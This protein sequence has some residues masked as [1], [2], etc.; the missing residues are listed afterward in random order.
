MMKN[1]KN[2]IIDVLITASAYYIMCSIT[3]YNSWQSIITLLIVA[4]CCVNNRAEKGEL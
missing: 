3:H 4:L 2:L 1:I